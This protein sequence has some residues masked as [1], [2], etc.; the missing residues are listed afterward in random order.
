MRRLSSVGSFSGNG[1]VRRCVEYHRLFH[2]EDRN[3]LPNGV[4]VEATLAIE[5]IARSTKVQRAV[6]IA[7]RA[8]Q[9]IQK[10]IVQRAN[11][12][13]ETGAGQLVAPWSLAVG[14]SQSF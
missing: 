11:T 10:P 4:C 3:Y 12:D 5:S 8:L 2:K 14:I 6:I 7:A 1:R 9:Q 13:P